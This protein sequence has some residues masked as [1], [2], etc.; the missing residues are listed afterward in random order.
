MKVRVLGIQS[1]TVVDGMTNQE[2][3]DKQIKYMEEA[4]EKELSLIHI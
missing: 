3:V 2:Y 1:G 4:V